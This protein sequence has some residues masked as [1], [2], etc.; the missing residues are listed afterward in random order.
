MGHL[1]RAKDLPVH[2]LNN[3][4]KLTPAEQ[5][6]YDLMQHGLTADRIAERLGVSMSTVH[7]RLKVIRQKTAAA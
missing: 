1:L 3:H 5:V 4:V 2:R 7:T 6:T